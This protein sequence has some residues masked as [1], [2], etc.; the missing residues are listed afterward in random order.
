MEG[1]GLGCRGVVKGPEES[2]RELVTWQG[3][4]YLFISSKPYQPLKYHLFTSIL[5]LKC[6]E[7]MV[8]VVYSIVKVILVL[9]E[10]GLGPRSSSKRT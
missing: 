8:A 7:T 1:L 6:K 3:L 5:L 4:Q 10:M 2:G 9:I